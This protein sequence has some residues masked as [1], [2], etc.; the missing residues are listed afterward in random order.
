M[1]VIHVNMVAVKGTFDL[2]HQGVVSIP[3]EF[4]RHPGVDNILNGAVQIIPD[5]DS[6]RRILLQLWKSV[7]GFVQRFF[8]IVCGGIIR[9]ADENLNP[10][11]GLIPGCLEEKPFCF[12]ESEAGCKSNR[13]VRP[14]PINCPVQCNHPRQK[15]G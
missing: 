1:R 4:G 10:A 14:G 5:V 13:S 7:Y 3:V 9:G 15:A 12:P 11:D 8:Y 6:G 2:F